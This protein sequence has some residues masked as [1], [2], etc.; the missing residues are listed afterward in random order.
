METKLTQRRYDLDWLRV[1]AFSGVFFY[2]CSRF[3]NSADWHLKNSSTSALVDIFTNIFDLWGMPLIFAISGAS[4][5]FALRPH[6]AVRFLRERATRLL[7]PMA[8][9][10]LVL[11]PPQVYFDRLTHARF[12][13]SF[14]EFIP[15]YFESGNIS[16]DGMHLWYLVYLF[17]FTI[18]LTPLFVWLKRPS[19]QKVVISIGNLSARSG[20]IYL[21]AIP[22]ALVSIVL[23]PF[24]M[25]RPSPSETFVRLVMYP[26]P[27]VYG[28]LIYANDG[29]QQAIV[30]QRRTSL[31]IALAFTLV[32]LLI[33]VGTS[34][35]G[36]K[37]SLPIYA[38]IMSLCSLL[39]WSYLLSA[40]GYGMRYL[41]ANKHFLSYANEAVLPFYI[42]HQPVILLLGYFIIQLPLP[43]LAKYL[44]IA[45][46]AFSIT[47]G[48][49]EYGIRR[50][51]LLRQAFGLKPR[52]PGI[53]SVKVAAQSLS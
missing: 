53:P 27:F 4:I 20:A 32:A 2:H 41:T 16:W 28:Y 25:L 52:K 18:A 13:G 1:L 42:L 10:I 19:G 11:A 29:I 35:W 17:T 12:S 9:G 46:L 48:L 36:W 24:G 37:F 34:E 30:R 5:F 45:P 51:N 31:V 38:V 40:F 39:I 21:W 26:L 23:D 50:V 14:L 43:I 8:I 6:A 44:L 7:V 33:S 22:V 49:Y 47:L 3:F 15:H